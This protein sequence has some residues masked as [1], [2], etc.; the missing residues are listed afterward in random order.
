[1]AT[2]P[3]LSRP[4]R[5]GPRSELQQLPPAARL[6]RAARHR[7]AAGRKAR[8]GSATAATCCGAT[9]RTTASCA[10]TRR[11]ARSASSASRR[12]TPTATPATARAGSS[13]ASTTRRR[14]TRTEYDGTITVLADSFDGKRLNSPN[15]VVVKS[16]GS[17]WFTDPPFGILGYYEGHKAEPELPTN[18]Y[19]V[20]RPDRQRHRD[21]RRRQPAQRPRLLARRERSSTSSSPRAMP[22]ARIRVY[23]VVDDGTQ[24]RPTAG[25]SSTPGRAARPTASASTS[26]AIC[27]AAGAWASAELD[28]VRVFNPPR[29]RSATSPCRSAAPTSASAAASATGCSWRP[30]TRSTR[31]TS[32]RRAWR[33]VRI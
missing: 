23:D 1:M 8:S 30:A 27:G 20:D 15:D 33:A 25:C 2:E 4:G 12:T 31:S 7:A 13:P 18:V 21:G 14:V 11:P 19:R 17:I 16:D 3:A 29:N 32:T 5:A 28:G 24:A 6:G 9:S 26:T 22:R 10:G